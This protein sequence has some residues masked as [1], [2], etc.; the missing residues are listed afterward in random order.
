MTVAPCETARVDEN[1]TVLVGAGS[2]ALNELH[3]SEHGAVHVNR[4][5]AVR[6]TG[7]EAT[8]IL[9]AWCKGVGTVRAIIG[10]KPRST[11]GAT[12]LCDSGWALA[13][14]DHFQLFRVKPAR[15]FVIVARSQ[16]ADI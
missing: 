11:L 15:E 1:V 3:S 2:P 10:F 12:P 6:P 7:L 9:T 5:S 13:L 16:V 4:G 14:P 8:V